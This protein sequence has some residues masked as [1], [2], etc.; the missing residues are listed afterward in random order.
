MSISQELDAVKQILSTIQRTYKLYHEK[1]KIA[2][3][4]TIFTQPDSEKEEDIDVPGDHHLTVWP[5]NINNIILDLLEVTDRLEAALDFIQI[6]LSQIHCPTKEIMQR[7]LILLLDTTVDKKIEKELNK[8][9]KLLNE[10]DITASYRYTVYHASLLRIGTILNHILLTFGPAFMYNALFEDQPLSRSKNNSPTINAT[11]ADEDEN[12]ASPTTNLKAFFKQNY[13][14]ISNLSS[15]ER[16]FWKTFALAFHL[17]RI[18]QDVAGHNASNSLIMIKGNL[19]LQF[20][21]NLITADIAYQAKE[22]RLLFSESILGK[23]LN[24]SGQLGTE[25]NKLDWLLQSISPF[26]KKDSARDSFEPSR[27]RA[28]IAE[29]SDDKNL[30]DDDLITNHY[31]DSLI[32]L[33]GITIYDTETTFTT[34]INLLAQKWQQSLTSIS[35]KTAQ[36][37]E[38]FAEKL[39][40]LDYFLLDPIIMRL[41]DTGFLPTK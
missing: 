11:A 19:L 22:K 7:L 6:F 16:P 17:A 9:K 27:R 4:S 13:L 20:L 24:V 37:A 31:G 10:N 26:Y 36:E 35:H 8:D 1:W 25:V 38:D 29:S 23:E 2:N 28:Q 15:L 14:L 21:N 18:S 12:D 33:I 41:K 32:E 39:I 40:K 3:V 5:S 30:F 34:F